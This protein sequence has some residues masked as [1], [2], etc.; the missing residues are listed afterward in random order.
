MTPKHLLPSS[1]PSS[2]SKK[3]RHSTGVP[4][5]PFSFAS[6]SLST[7]Y[8]SCPSDSPSNP[9]GRT[10]TWN[11][12]Q[13]LPPP[14][15]FSQ[16]LPL[17]FQ[18]IKRG[19]PREALEGI[20]RVVQVP[21]SYTLVHL[22]SLIGFL[23]GGAYGQVPPEDDEGDA[24]VFE[25]KK[26]VTVYAATFRPGQ[27]MYGDTWAYSS[28]ALDPY[29]YYPDWEAEDDSLDIKAR[30]DD[31]RQWT[32]EEDMTV[33]HV[34]PDGGDTGRGI[35]YKHSSHLQIHITINTTPIHSR[36]GKGNLPHVFSAC[37]L[38][39]LDEPR[40]EDN[41]EDEDR[42]AKLD[43]AN[44]N[45]PENAFTQY[46]GETA[47]LPLAFSGY[48]DKENAENSS[49]GAVPE[50]SFSSSPL[51]PSSAFSSPSLATPSSSG[52][53]PRIGSVLRSSP[54]HSFPKYTPA[55]RASQRKRIRHLQ[56]RIGT[57]TRGLHAEEERAKGKGKPKPKP[58]DRWKKK[59][60]VVD[61]DE[62]APGRRARS[63]E[64]M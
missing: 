43:P 19:V 20:Y 28:S 30:E 42:T 39:Y 25:A 9:F 36:R 61:S 14:T 22:K 37:G 15:S 13:A 7:P 55:P 24:H 26:S 40:E 45:E 16:H 12:L 38:V 32:A 59:R 17:R 10:R 35:V 31:E 29:L 41:L 50:L 23:F 11:L 3:R 27:I 6:S 18:Y 44:W 2:P 62:P 47:I 64:I 1:S 52:R 48:G 49:I 33:A 53:S 5:S 54:G 46:Y 21:Q 34:W 58:Y 8:P 57:L 63:E 51:R 60:T 4:S 56:H